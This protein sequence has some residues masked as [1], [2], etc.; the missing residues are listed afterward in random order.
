MAILNE[1]IRAEYTG[2]SEIIDDYIRYEIKTEDD[3]IFYEWA[4]IVSSEFVD[5]KGNTIK[6]DDLEF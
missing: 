4:E 5:D 2:N 6:Y 1:K 3:R